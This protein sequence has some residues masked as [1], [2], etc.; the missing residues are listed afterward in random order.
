M[1]KLI[2]KLFLIAI[3]LTTLLSSCADWE[4]TVQLNTSVDK[5]T[6]GRIVLV[7]EFTGASCPNC[8]AGSA[9]IDKLLEKYPDNVVVMGIHSD[10]LGSPRRPGEVKLKTKDAQDIDDFTGPAVFGKPEITVNRYKFPNQNQIRIGGLPDVWTG[11]VEQELKISPDA[12]LNIN[13]TY[14]EITR[15]VLIELTVTAKKTIQ[16]AIN[17]HA[18]ITESNIINTQANTGG[19]IENYV[20]KHVLRKVITP[21]P[22]E[23]IA[24]AM[25]PGQVIKKEYHYTLP[26]DAILWK[27]ENCNVVGFI[28]L[29]DAQ[30]YVLQ[31]AEAP[32]IK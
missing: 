8:P 14:D 6:S 22:G 4:Q 32:V 24:D 23:K 16:N 31:A 30:K 7:E 18:A 13:T 11:Y 28:S 25:Q 15:D 10:F 29:N 9:Q 5:P 2:H 19:D 17:I 12:I 21:I 1:K 26:T 27:A 3:V 20:N